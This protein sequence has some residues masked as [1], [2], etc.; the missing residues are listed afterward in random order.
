MPR[1][2]AVLTI[3][4]ML[5]MVLT[6]ALLMKR[7]GIEAM[8]FGKID[9]TDFLIP[10][11]A[12]FYFYIVFAATFNFLTVSA[13]EFFHSGVSGK[14]GLFRALAI[15][16]CPPTY[17]VLSHHLFICRAENGSRFFVRAR[18]ARGFPFAASA[19]RRGLFAHFKA[20]YRGESV[21]FLST[22]FQ[23]QGDASWLV[24]RGG[25]RHGL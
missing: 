6:R 19:L 7:N 12:L 25:V 23:L 14:I 10:P 3:V 11:F 20:V 5:G 16:A 2:F 8:N 18:S 9:K 17:L 15:D 21:P 13:Q 22:L 4:L 24:H 1:Y